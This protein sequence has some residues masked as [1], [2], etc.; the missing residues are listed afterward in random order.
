MYV[1][2]AWNPMVPISTWYCQVFALTIVVS[3]PFHNFLQLLFLVFCN[4]YWMLQRQF[5]SL[6]SAA[7]TVLCI[8]ETFQYVSLCRCRFRRQFHHVQELQ[9]SWCSA[10]FTI[11]IITPYH[12]WLEVILYMSR[13]HDGDT[14]QTW[15]IKEK[16]HWDWVQFTRRELGQIQWTWRASRIISPGETRWWSW[17]WS[18]DGCT[19]CKISSD[20][21]A[22][23]QQHQTAESTKECTQERR[24]ER[25]GT[26]CMQTHQ[27]TFIHAVIE[28]REGPRNLFL[29]WTACWGWQ[30]SESFNIPIGQTGAWLC[31]LSW[32]CRTAGPSQ[33]WRHD[34]V[35]RPVSPTVLERTL[36][37]HKKGPVNRITGHKPRTSSVGSCLRWTSP[38]H[39]RN[40]TRWGDGTSI[41]I[42]WSCPALSIPNGTARSQSQHESPLHTTE[43]ETPGSVSWHAGTHQKGKTSWWHWK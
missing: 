42:G 30:S 12:N 27:V 20:M 14:D 36:Q 18:C 21:Q 39:W 33:W 5:Y 2:W 17:Y 28:Y 32:W 31:N 8:L 37:S 41:H 19:R 13:G 29:L 40:Q 9:T 23:V 11:N 4:I 15:P 25:W 16:R 6:I 43:T 22:P 24:W 35:G 1:F 34:S 7:A 26:T 10:N 3:Y 38:V